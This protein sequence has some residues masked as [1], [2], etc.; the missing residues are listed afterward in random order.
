MA[1][2]LSVVAVPMAWVLAGM[3]LSE[4]P[5]LFF[6]AVSLCLQLI[7]LEVIDQP[8]K[9]LGLFALRRRWHCG[10]A[11]WGR[12]PYLLLGGVPVVLAIRERRLRPAAALFCAMVLVLSVPQFVIWKGL[13]PPSHQERVQQGLAPLNALL[14]L[15][16]TGLCFFLLAPRTRWTSAA[17]AAI[18]V[19]G[20]DRGQRNTASR[21]DRAASHGRR[22]LCVH[23]GGDAVRRVLRRAVPRLRS[24]LSSMAVQGHLGSA[25]TTFG[26]SWSTWAC[27]VSPCRPSSSVISTRADI[28]A[29]SLP[30]MILAAEPW[31]RWGVATG[32]DRHRWSC[33]RR[34]V[35]RRLFHPMSNRLLRR[36]AP[37]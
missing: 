22:A 17:W 18:L 12:Q 9:L 20:G 4:M 32:R 26:P 5:A 23:Q 30:Y 35:A 28:T 36:A 31:R 11:V 2:A 21:R 34:R 25:G 8:R 1:S 24:D 15:G 27:C 14:S 10:I 16:Y 29:M 19:V 6:V 3:A 37:E 7:A 33:D 13:V